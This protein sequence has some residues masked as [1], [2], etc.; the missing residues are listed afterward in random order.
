MMGRYGYEKEIDEKLADPK[1][2]REYLAP[3]D[4]AEVEK[5]EAQRRDRFAREREIQKWTTKV[6]EHLEATYGEKRH[7]G[8][9]AFIG[10]GERVEFKK[11]NGHLKLKW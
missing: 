6:G 11:D 1:Y 7:D 10:Y 4:R 5:L 2:H 9:G 8:N 3:N